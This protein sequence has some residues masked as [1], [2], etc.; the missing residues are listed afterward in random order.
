[1]TIAEFFV[2]IG[3]NVQSKSVKEVLGTLQDLP[4]AALESIAA[5]AGVEYSLMKI[6][7][8]AFETATSLQLFTSETGLSAKE[9]QKWQIVAEQSNVSAEAV[10]SSINT[11]QRNLAEI[12]LGRGNIAP[13]QILGVGVNQN[14]FGVLNQL[15]QR[16]KG[17]DPAMATNLVSQMGLDPSFIHLLQLTDKEFG[18]LSK[19]VSGLTND[20]EGSLL[21]AKQQLVQ[22]GLVMRYA[23][24]DL[25]VNLSNGFQ[26]LMDKLSHFKGVITAIGVALVGL[27]AY[28]FPVTAA[29][30][31][32]ILVL[33]DLSVYF[34]GG[35]SVT[36]LAIEG[37]KKLVDALDPFAGKLGNLGK[38][39]SII[40]ALANPAGAAASLLPAAV[41]KVFQ[42]TNTINVHS[43]APAQE[44]GKAVKAEIDKGVTQAALQSDNQGY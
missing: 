6:T 10:A 30:V 36:G 2:T 41:S 35:N 28:F 29:I 13:F 18:N 44:V 19:T 15:R 42:Q 43:T 24:F 9:L 31:G 26:M 8:Q 37:I 22:L 33:D 14:A 21:K 5:L 23:G 20:Q 27:A 7:Q 11:L 1:M 39:G 32:L 3:F 17:L 12:R 40:G 16:L 25:V 38:I 4:I 34:Q